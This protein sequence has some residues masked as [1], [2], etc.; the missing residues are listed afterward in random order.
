MKRSFRTPRA[1]L[2]IAALLTAGSLSADIIVLKTGEKIDCTIL[3]ETD[4]TLTYKYMLTAKI[5]DTKTIPKA[6]IKELTRFTPAQVEFEAK[7]LD[8][9]L[10]TRDL[11]SASEYESIIQDDLRTFVAKYPGTPEAKKVEEMIAT[12]SDEKAKVLGGQV[13]MEGKWLDEATAKRENYNIEAY[14]LRLAMKSA[15]EDVSQDQIMPKEIK[16]LREFENLRTTYPASMQFLQGIDEALEI[17]D[18]YDKR[19]AAM[20]LDQPILKAN[21]DKALSTTTG[22]DLEALKNAIEQEERNFKTTEEAQKKAK[23]KWKDIYKYDVKSLQEAQALVAKEKQDLKSINKSALQNEIE[24][25]NAAIRYIA[26]GNAAEA[27]VVMGR[28][29]PTKNSLMNKKVFDEYDKKLKELQMKIAKEMKATKAATAAAAPAPGTENAPESANPIA[30]AL[31][32]KKAAAK[33]KDDARIAKAKADSAG[34]SSSSKGSEAPEEEQTMLQKINKYIPYIGAG[35]L[36]VLII[37]MVMGK[38]KK[39]DED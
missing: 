30:E 9:L 16:A 17:L 25:L 38:K 34:S 5:S 23:V 18:K 11:M 28:L 13:K 6:D 24:N 36:V 32:K 21:R 26:D 33:A 10:P 27:E 7:H 20:R 12:L 19:L 31:A 3:S 22:T 35:L 39:E 14:R 4:T 8:K 2:F 29:R 15:E 1:L 37:A